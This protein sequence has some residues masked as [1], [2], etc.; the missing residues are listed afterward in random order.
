MFSWLRSP[1]SQPEPE[2][3]YRVGTCSD[4]LMTDLVLAEIE[5]ETL[6]FETE[7]EMQRSEQNLREISADYSWLISDSRARRRKYLSMQERLRVENLCFQI[8]SDEWNEVMNN[9]RARTKTPSKREQIIEA[10]SAAVNDVVN[11]RPRPASVADMLMDYIMQRPSRNQVNDQNNG[12]ISAD[13]DTHMTALSARSDSCV[14]PY[15]IV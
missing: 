5:S 15:H 12:S 1:R 3:R 14:Q 11:S 10:F 13:D 7:Q 8:G 4:R 6:K 9:W 2:S